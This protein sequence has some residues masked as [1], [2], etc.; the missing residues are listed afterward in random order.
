MGTCG[1]VGIQAP[2]LSLNFNL[3]SLTKLSVGIASVGIMAVGII[4][5][6]STIVRFVVDLLYTTSGQITAYQ[7]GQRY[8]MRAHYSYVFTR[9]DE[10]IAKTTH[11][12]QL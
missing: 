10:E 1:Y 9:R 2:M 6:S 4:S 12:H 5:N 7:E 3:N 8:T 11:G